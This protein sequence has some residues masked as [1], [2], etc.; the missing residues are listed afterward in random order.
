MHLKVFVKLK[1]KPKIPL[2]WAKKPKKTQKTPKKPKKPKK[3]QKNPKKHTGL[4]FF[5]KKPG[6][7]P[8]LIRIRIQSGSRALITKLR[9]K[10]TA[11]KKK[12]LYQKLQFTYP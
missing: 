5:K 4:G 1:K 6:F 12:I 11:G 10:I 3:N 9:K 2:V 7:F 8:S